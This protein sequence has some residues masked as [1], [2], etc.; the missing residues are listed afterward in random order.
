MNSKI[1]FTFKEKD[2]KPFGIVLLE[3]NCQTKSKSIWRMS[4]V[5][6]SYHIKTF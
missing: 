4:Q 2:E 3:K 1:E 5:L 6:I